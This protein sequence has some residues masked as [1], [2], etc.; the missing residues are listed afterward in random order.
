MYKPVVK[1]AI[2]VAAITAFGGL[3][4]YAAAQVNNTPSPQVVIPSSTVTEDTTSS[5]LTDDTLGHDVNDDT[6]SSSV[7]DDTVGH[8]ANDDNGD[9]TTGTDDPAGH[10]AGDDHGGGGHS[11]D[12]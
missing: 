4:T 5:S 12:D 8:D 7:S 2:A 3:A 6:T 1:T 10:D 9:V 11:A